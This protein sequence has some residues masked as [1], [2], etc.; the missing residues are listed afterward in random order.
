MLPALRLGF[1]VAPDWAMR[2][3]I[4][5]KN[6]LDWHC[7][8]PTQMGVARFIADGHL[9]RHVRKLRGIYQQRRQVLLDILREDLGA[10][11]TPLTSFY[12]MHIAA[13]A[14]RPLDL[15]R[16]TATLLNSNVKLHSLSRYFLGAPTR[17]GLIFGYGAVDLPEIKRGLA[18]LRGS[19]K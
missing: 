18:A 13:T 17:A 19:L 14:L 6:S 9:T 5:A 1:I 11:L 3:L 12:G 8:T 15:D 10:W 16:I 4:A 2:T 7:P